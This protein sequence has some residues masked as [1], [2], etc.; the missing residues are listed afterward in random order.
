MNFIKR[1]HE[2]GLYI[3]RNVHAMYTI[4]FHSSTL[5]S[6]VEAL[7]MDFNFK[8]CSVLNSLHVARS[9]AGFKSKCGIVVFTH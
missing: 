7:M 1:E 8:P 4:C 2:F 6:Y 5:I 3:L 9:V